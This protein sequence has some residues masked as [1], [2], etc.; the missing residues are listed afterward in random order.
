MVMTEVVGTVRPGS[1]L[2]VQP[3]GFVDG[4]D[5]GNDHKRGVR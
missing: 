1:V 2:E 5:A 3:Y 4:L